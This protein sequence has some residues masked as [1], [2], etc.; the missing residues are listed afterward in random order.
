MTEPVVIIKYY[1][2]KWWKRL[3]GWFLGIFGYKHKWGII[4]FD[5]SGSLGFS[6]KVDSPFKDGVV[7]ISG[8]TNYAELAERINNSEDWK[9]YCDD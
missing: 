3:W 1:P 4:E 2:D 5:S 8:E 6:E 7:E 9:M